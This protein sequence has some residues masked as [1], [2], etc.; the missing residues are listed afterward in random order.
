MGVDVAHLIGTKLRIFQRFAH[1]AV[2]AV[3]IFRGLRDMEGVAGHAVADDLGE[4]LG[5]APAR[6]LQIFQHQDAS[7]FADHKTVAIFVEGAAGALRLF[8]THRKRAHG[9]ESADAHWRD[10]RFRAA[11]DHD[12]GGAAGDDL[13]GVAHR[14]SARGARCARSRVRPLGSVPDGDVAGGQVHDTGGNEEG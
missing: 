2:G 6:E 9:G 13:E 3:G 8:V 11:A 5:P 7:S 14:M 12:I 1:G 10:A 4:D